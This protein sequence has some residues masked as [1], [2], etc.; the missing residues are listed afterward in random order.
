MS[1]RAAVAI[2]LVAAVAAGCGIP[3]DEHATFQPAGDVPFGLLE[4]TTSTALTAPPPSAVT[5]RVCF[6][7]STDIIRPATRAMPTG[8]TPTELLRTL[9]EGPTPE[10]RNQGWTTA[11]TG[12]E[13]VDSIAVSG[14]VARTGLSEQFAAMPATDQ[15]TA[16]A[17]FVCTLTA[18]PGIGQV[19]FAI[20]GSPAEVP[21]GDGSGTSDPVSRADY[22]NLIGN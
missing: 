17:Q 10:E 15:L 11:V 9:G 18:Q 2:A 16:V 7:D 8:F 1:A 13:L 21:R 19:Q 12:A 5:A 20:D 3:T 4:T 22:E 14:G 6:V